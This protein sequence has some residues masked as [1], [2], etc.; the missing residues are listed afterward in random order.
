MKDRILNG[1]ESKAS[2]SG[3]VS[4]GGR[5]NAFNSLTLPSKPTGL[6]AT[7]TSL[8]SIRLTWNDVADEEGYRIERKAGEEGA[9]SR[10]ATL[11][12]DQTSYTDN[13]V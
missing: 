13:D 11:G 6:S 5:I 10:V 3:K 1:A 4:T 8:T 7:L 12:S 9:F 2:L